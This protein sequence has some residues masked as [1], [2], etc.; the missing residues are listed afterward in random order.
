LGNL[1]GNQNHLVKGKGVRQG[2]R[3]RRERQE[4]KEGEK[5]EESIQM[6]IQD[7]E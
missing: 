6:A 5:R 3:E 7:H 4:S 1:T 2:W